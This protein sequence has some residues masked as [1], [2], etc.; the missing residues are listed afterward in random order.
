MGTSCPK[1]FLSLPHKCE[2]GLIGGG[3]GAVTSL[4]NWKFKLRSYSEEKTQSGA[5]NRSFLS[6]PLKRYF[7]L[8]GVPLKLCRFI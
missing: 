5:P 6:D 3:E 7:R 4:D 8:S 1:N 2:P